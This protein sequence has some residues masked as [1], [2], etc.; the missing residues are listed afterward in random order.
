MNV[1]EEYQSW[2]P[3]N[4]REKRIIS[5]AYQYINAGFRALKDA[6]LE[7]HTEDDK[8]DIEDY[9]E[10][11]DMKKNPYK[12]TDPKPSKEVVEFHLFVKDRKAKRFLQP[13]A[14]TTSEKP[15]PAAGEGADQ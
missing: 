11:L 9:A 4:W 7:G 8:Q 10:A 12:Y 5:C 13:V 1:L 2:F 6:I 15:T 14:A 3:P